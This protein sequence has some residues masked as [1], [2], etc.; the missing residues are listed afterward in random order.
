[1]RL[2]RLELTNFRGFGHLDLE[3]HPNFNVLIGVNGVGKTTVLEAA[4]VA[5]SGWLLSFPGADTRQIRS[6]DVRS[7][8]QIEG[9]RYRSLKQFPG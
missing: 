2:R 4:A 3:F 6:G 8:G 5:L 9:S 1:M 7:S